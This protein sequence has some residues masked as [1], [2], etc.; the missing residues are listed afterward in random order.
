[1]Y[2]VFN[3]G[4]MKRI[5][6]RKLVPGMVLAN[7]VHTYNSSL[8]LLDKGTVLED[9]DIARLAFYSIIDVLIEDDLVELENEFADITNDEGL[10][11]SERI[12]QS[13]E[14]KEF[15]HS[16]EE[17]AEKFEHTIKD[18][19]E[20]NRDLVFD[21]MMAPIYGLLEKGRSS[22]NI[23]DML[24]WDRVLREG[25][26]LTAEEQ[27]QMYTPAVLNGEEAYS[28]EDG[29]GYGF[30]WSV[31]Q[32]PEHG[33]IVSHSGGM[34]GVHTWFERFIDEDRMLLIL[35]S[36]DE[37]DLRAHMG[38]Y[39]G[40]MDIMKDKEPEPIRSI[41]DIAVKDPDKSNWERFCGKYERPEDEDFTIEE[42][43]LKD[44]ELYAKA[45]DD[46]GDE[47]EFRLYPIGENEFG[48]KLGMVKLTF[49]EDS[50]TYIGQ[51]CKKIAE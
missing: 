46:D 8:K 32:D 4:I 29:D 45:I 21:D 35:S 18:I 36:R 10:T 9:K 43:C 13:P 24:R 42:V 49:S 20:N 15:K 19:I 5:L 2:F 37:L 14:F 26:V 50:V 33:L 39:N 48:R 41:E 17:C 22:A 28:D 7:D 16:F 25:S 47:F 44:G 34:P 27:K 31:T 11:Y 51:T 6:T 40:L 3:E 12:K 1:M 38:F 30:G 23:F